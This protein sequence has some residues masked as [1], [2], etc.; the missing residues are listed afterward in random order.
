M[1]TEIASA[2]QG[3]AIATALRQS[4]WA[5]PLVNA[6]HIVG[7]A[8]LFGAIV[9]LD[10]RLLGV[11]RQ[12]PLAAM[13]RILLPVAIAGLVLAVSTGA[14]LFSVRATEYVAMPLFWL[15]FSLIAGA[16]ANALLLRLSLA[17]TVH[18]QSGLAGTMPRL[19]LAGALSIGLWL[20][21]IVAGRMIGYL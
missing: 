18:E 2:L 6:G 7:L 1:L 15:K 4:F 9:P 12:L 8:L 14:L 21:V 17:W 11:W 10:L 5:Y 20:A 16:I 13:G 3:S 19:Q